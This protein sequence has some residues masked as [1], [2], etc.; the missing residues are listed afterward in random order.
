[1]Q[2]T[3]RWFHAHTIGHHVET[4]PP[5]RFYAESYLGARDPNGKY[6]IPAM[7][8]PGIV[9]VVLGYP[10]YAGLLACLTGGTVAWVADEIHMAVHVRGTWME[11]VPLFAE[12]RQLHILHHQ[13]T[14]QQNYGIYDFSLDFLFGTMRFA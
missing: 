12:L 6:Y 1:M 10:W 9:V 13:G 8:G 7:F 3:P 11:R 14:A 5:S 2:L 4:Y